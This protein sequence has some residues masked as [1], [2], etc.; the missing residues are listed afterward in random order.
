MGVVTSNYKGICSRSKTLLTGRFRDRKANVRKNLPKVFDDFS[1]DD[2]RFGGRQRSGALDASLVVNDC[3]TK[4]NG[5]TRYGMVLIDG[6]DSRIRG[7]SIAHRHHAG[8]H[9]G[10]SIT[11]T[12][13][14]GCIGMM[15][16]RTDQNVRKKWGASR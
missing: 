13:S 15:V 6:Q 1:G 14:L 3:T 5:H 7:I 9:D 2:L 11:I 8:H 10:N 12:G 4:T 16:P